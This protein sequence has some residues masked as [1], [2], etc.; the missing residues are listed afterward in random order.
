MS[1]AGLPAGSQ[2]FFLLLQNGEGVPQSLQ[3]AGPQAHHLCC[4]GSL[5]PSWLLIWGD[6]AAPRLDCREGQREGEP[7]L[8][9]WRHLLMMC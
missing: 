8:S 7:S 5:E 3:R 6:R 4:H 9:F 1:R 2:T